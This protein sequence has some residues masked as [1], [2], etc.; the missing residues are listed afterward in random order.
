MAN[1]LVEEG[2]RSP[3]HRWRFFRSG[4][5]DQ[6]RL[7][8]GADLIS[9]DQLDQKLWVALSC[10][11][12]GLE[13]DAKTLEMIDSDGDGRIR[14]PDI[15]AAVKWAGSLLRN[16]EALTKGL[17]ELPLSIINDQ[18]PEGRR[19][20][21][22]AREILANLGKP[23]AEVISVEDTD[24]TA[25]IFSLAR[26]NGDGFIPADSTDDAAVRQ[27]ITEI[28]DCLGPETDRS[29]KPA[30]SQEM[31]GHT[32]NGIRRRRA[33]PTFSRWRT[34]RYPLPR[35]SR[36]SGERWTTISPVA[37]SSSMIFVP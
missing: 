23:E 26:F 35:P 27:V 15:I 13:F 17:S 25:R 22:S 6:V 37:G 5:F 1:D 33:K 9:L 18:L 30:V 10:P 4:G 8:T 16:P 14:V 19:L 24:D 7:E 31:S 34:P 12:K 32:R 29:G 20:I 11:V 36:P 28:I 21:N 2:S 3:M